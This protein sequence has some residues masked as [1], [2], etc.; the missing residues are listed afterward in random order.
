MRLTEEQIVA[1]RQLAVELAGDQVRVRVFGSRLDDTA[2]G[3]DLDIMLVLPEPVDNAALLAA[4]RAVDEHNASVDARNAHAAL[5][6][7]LDGD[8]M[9]LIF[10]KL[11][12]LLLSEKV[13]RAF[14][15]RSTFCCVS[16]ITRGSARSG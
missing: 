8:G 1:I 10:G 5:A 14:I 13:L 16:Q 4:Q 15:A 6:I 7:A 2:R 3:G 11:H 12:R 9:L